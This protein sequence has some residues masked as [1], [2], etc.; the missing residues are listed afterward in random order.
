MEELKDRSSG[1]LEIGIRIPKKAHT[2]GAPSHS[3]LRFLR[4]RERGSVRE[5]SE[6]HHEED[7][8]K[9]HLTQSLLL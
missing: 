6:E 2:A 4:G 3:A 9:N 7:K 1:A 8:N 5:G